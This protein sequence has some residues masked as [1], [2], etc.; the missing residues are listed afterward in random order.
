MVFW[1]QRGL[2]ESLQSVLLMS[3]AGGGEA[4]GDSSPAARWEGISLPG[5]SVLQK[6]ATASEGGG[7]CRWDGSDTQEGAR[8]QPVLLGLW[9]L[10]LPALS[11]HLVALI[12]LPAAGGKHFLCCP[13]WRS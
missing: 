5:A 11:L 3:E 7:L 12:L 4:G 6:V 1:S 13:T 8:S 9:V 10:R 2:G